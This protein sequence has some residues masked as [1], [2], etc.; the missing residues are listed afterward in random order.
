MCPLAFASPMTLMTTDATRWHVFEKAICVVMK[1]RLPCPNC[2]ATAEKS[3]VARSTVSINRPSM[4]HWLS[5]FAPEN[6]SGAGAARLKKMHTKREQLKNYSTLGQIDRSSR[7]R[8]TTTTPPSSVF[9]D[10]EYKTRP[11]SANFWNARSGASSETAAN[12]RP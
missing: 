3:M 7:G 11:C 2:C 5:D 10:S 1:R 4:I 9:R 8:L 6:L 12:F